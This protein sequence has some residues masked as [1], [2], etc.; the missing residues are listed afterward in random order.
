[1]AATAF[2]LSGCAAGGS[3]TSSSSP[4]PTAACPRLEDVPD[5]ERDCAVYDPDAAMAENERYREEVPLAP[6]D[7]ADLDTLVDPARTALEALP[8]PATVDDVVAAL[9]SIG[10]HEPDIQTA[11][12]GTG[13]VFGAAAGGGCLRG[14]VA[15]DGAVTVEAGGFIM[16]GGCL[17]AS[18]H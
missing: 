2:L 17:A 5:E 8:T 18:G 12:N 9:V 1:M 3:P 7:Q 10:I 4:T 6:G 13:V 16:D 11:D 15:P 14:L